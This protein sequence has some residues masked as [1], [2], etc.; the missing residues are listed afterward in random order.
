MVTR[1]FGNYEIALYASFVALALLPLLA[2]VG[3]LVYRQGYAYAR[4]YALAWLVYGAGLWLSMLT[5][6]T[7]LF[8][9]SLTPLVFA[10]LGSALES[11]FLLI[12][13]CERFM[14]WDNERQLAVRLAEQDELTGLGNRRKLRTV[15]HEIAQR[16][17]VAKQPLFLLLVRFDNFSELL[18]E[19]GHDAAEQ[20][21][22]DMGLLLQRLASKSDVCVRYN[23]EDFVI[24]FA[25]ESART[26]HDVALRILDE[27]QATPTVVRGMFIRN[28]IRM[29]MTDIRQ[30]GIVE[31]E[32]QV[33]QRAYQA[34][35]H[36]GLST[37]PP[38]CFIRGQQSDE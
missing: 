1:L 35:E 10:Q 20:M 22:K 16:D 15:F 19:F 4:W 36:A 28:R 11:I 6:A 8:A 38:F 33:I 27:A 23:G 13:V 14:V 32:H 30:S 17:S 5:A 7:D 18:H 31:S 34:L 24:I 3:W 9:W 25:A 21:L 2:L 29:G 37:T 12:A 26:A